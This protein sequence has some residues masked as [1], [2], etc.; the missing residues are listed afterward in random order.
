VE[1]VGQLADACSAGA[2]AGVRPRGP[3]AHRRR[4]GTGAGQTLPEAPLL[5][6]AATAAGVAAAATDIATPAL[7]PYVTGATAAAALAVLAAA[8]AA[9]AGEGD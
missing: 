4:S 3:R 5:E 1:V 7:G 9:A 6:A 8:A 2:A